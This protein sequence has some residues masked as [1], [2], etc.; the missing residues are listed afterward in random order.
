MD[1]I[2]F[3]LYVSRGEDLKKRNENRLTKKQ[4]TPRLIISQQPYNYNFL[5]RN[6]SLGQ[7]N[8]MT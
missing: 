4:R 5:L 3:Y 1:L 8:E 7:I 6:A 2:Q